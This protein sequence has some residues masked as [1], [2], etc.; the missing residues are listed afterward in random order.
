MLDDKLNLIAAWFDGFV[1]SFVALSSEEQRNYALKIEH[2]DRVSIIMER[3]AASLNLSADERALAAIIA[4][5]HDVG[6]FPQ[7]KKYGTFNDATSVNHAALAVET[8]KE[9]GI[10]EGLDGKSRT[11]ILQA[12]ALHN[13][14][15]LPVNLSPYIRR[16]AMLI[17]DADKLDIWRV[18]IEYCSAPPQERAS[19]VVWEL[20]DKGC[21]SRPA[22][23]EVIAGRMINRSLLATADDFKLLQLSWA[24]DLNF[25]ESFKLLSERGYIETLAAL[26]PDQPECGEA[27]A[28][29]RDFIKARAHI[30]S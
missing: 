16:F 25:T 22:L 28:V 12:I 30:I 13:V 3:L 23:A 26:L 4:I 29:V 15:T 19:A 9:A 6:R 2:T 10:L 7:Y 14:F 21:C 27:V 1:A 24:F 11:L 5:C 18:L 17:R 20:P 8:L